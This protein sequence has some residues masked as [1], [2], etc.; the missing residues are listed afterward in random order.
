MNNPFDI[1]ACPS[2]AFVVDD[3]LLTRNLELLR[4][5]QQDSG[6]RIL[7][8]LKGFAMWDTFP[9]VS[10]YLVGTT[11]SGQ[12]EARLGAETFGGEVHCFSPAFSDAEMEVVL[13]YADH[14]SFNSPGQWLHHRE[15]VAAHPRAISCGLRV[16]PEHSEGTVALYDPCTPGSRLGTRVRDL[17]GVDLTGLDGLHFHTLCEQNS[18]ALERTLGAFEARFGQYLPGLKWVNFG[19][20][21]HITRPDY[22]IERLIKLVRGFRERHNRIPVYLE[23]GE[24]IALNT[25]YLVSTVLDIID[26]EGPIAI[27][28]TSATAHMP[29]V[30]EMPYRPE[31]IGAG[32]PEEKAHTYRLGG[33]TCLAGDMIGAYSFD[34]PLNIGDRL[35]FTDMAH[36]SMVKT[37][38]FNGMRLP[39]ICRVDAETR[40]V[41]VVRTFGYEAYKERLS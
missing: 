2:P 13:Q 17:E 14:I 18:D 12:D 23:P 26:N 8:A 10:Q 4:Q 20:G 32:M 21:H 39:A 5:V 15:R 27:L 25:G 22:D 28:D 37:N 16:N 3:A 40:E 1:Q 9:L 11:A 36:Y 34:Q 29:D 31:I 33:L 30:L 41:R 7:L 35:V 19:G 6:A 24:A 38:T